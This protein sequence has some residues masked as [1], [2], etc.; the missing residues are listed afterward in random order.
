MVE[1]HSNFTFEGSK[2]S[3]GGM[4]PTNH[5]L[6]ETI[7]ITHGFTDRCETGSYIFTAEQ[8]GQGIDWG[9]RS[10][11]HWCAHPAEMEMASRI[12][13][14]ERD[15]LPAAAIFRRY[16]DV[17]DAADHR[18]ADRLMVFVLQSCLR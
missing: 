13:P 12:E 7:E 8:N 18:S 4:Y 14:F 15:R 17:G 3:Q 6:H 16:L 11:S 9:W 1:L 5:R 2:T 10:R